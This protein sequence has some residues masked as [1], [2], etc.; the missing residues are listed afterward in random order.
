MSRHAQ[1]SHGLRKRCVENFHHDDKKAP[2]DKKAPLNYKTTIHRIRYT[3]T[4]FNSPHRTIQ[5]THKYHCCAPKAHHYHQ[6]GIAPNSLKPLTMDGN[7]EFLHGNYEILK[8]PCKS[9]MATIEFWMAISKFHGCHNETVWQSWNFGG[10]R[11]FSWLPCYDCH[12][13]VWKTWNIKIAMQILPY[14]ISRPS[15]LYVFALKMASNLPFGPIFMKFSSANSQKRIF[16][17]YLY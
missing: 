13:E 9:D 7:Y 16:S 15:H 4:L 5:N 17:R 2:P 3:S 14:R 12:R 1:V 6:T 8:L 10:L 11:Y